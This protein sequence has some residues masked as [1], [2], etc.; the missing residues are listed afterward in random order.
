M[1]SGSSAPARSVVNFVED[2]PITTKRLNEVDYLRNLMVRHMEY[3]DEKLYYLCK[4]YQLQHRINM[5]HRKGTRRRQVAKQKGIIEEVVSI[6]D[7][8]ALLLG[9]N[10]PTVSSVRCYIDNERVELSIPPNKMNG[11]RS[12]I[13]VNVPDRSVLSLQSS[14]TSIKWV[15]VCKEDDVSIRD[16]II[17][18]FEFPF[19]SIPARIFF[20]I[21]ILLILLSIIALALETVPKYNPEIYVLPNQ[22]DD[23]DDLEMKWWIIELIVT[24]V[25]SIETVV[26]LVISR[27]RISLLKK[28]TTVTD[29][30]AVLPFYI[31]LFSSHDTALTNVLK[32]CRLFR[33]M[34]FFRNY[35]PIEN[36][37]RAIEKSTKALAAPMMFLVASL[38]VMSSA[39]YFVE[40]G[41]YDEI[42]QQFMVT[43]HSCTSRPSQIFGSGNETE[44]RHESKFISIPHTIWWSIVTMTTVGYG[45]IVPL[46][47]FG[48]MVGSLSMILGIMFMAMPIAIVGSYFTVVV[49]VSTES[50][51]LE[52]TGIADPGEDSPTNVS[53]CSPGRSL[54][55]NTRQRLGYSPSTGHLCSPT[56]P[57]RPLVSAL[58]QSPTSK[59]PKKAVK[60]QL[61]ES[62]RD[63]RVS[64]QFS[65]NRVNEMERQAANSNTTNLT[66]GEKL[67]VFL[68]QVLPE[69][70]TTFSS[71]GFVHHLDIWLDVN[72]CGAEEQEVK[73]RANSFADVESAASSTQRGGKRGRVRADTVVGVPTFGCL[74]LIEKKQPVFINDQN[75]TLPPPIVWLMRPMIFTVGSQCSALPDPDI[76]LCTESDLG[77]N[78]R[79]SQR[80]AEIL[81][82]KWWS[83]QPSCKLRPILPSRVTVNGC[84]IPAAGIALR[85]GDVVDFNADVDN[86]DQSDI[87]SPASIQP[88]SASGKRGVS[89]NRTHLTYRYRCDRYAAALR[90]PVLALSETRKC[91]LAT[92][93]FIPTRQ[94]TGIE[95]WVT[96]VSNPTVDLNDTSFGLTNP[97]APLALPGPSSVQS[98]DDVLG[99]WS[100]NF[101]ITS[102]TSTNIL[103]PNILSPALS[104]NTTERRPFDL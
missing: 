58:S 22:T 64:E 46:T 102:P 20:V 78:V 54:M 13:W 67:A 48:K 33:M 91:A 7:G 55:S 41:E 17:N 84:L 29:I 43:D 62:R 28:P 47:S 23:K 88:S 24:I 9:R 96:N 18:F 70:H 69:Y 42:A 104:I 1:N 39:V 87:N 103:K 11:E 40:K 38:L 31:E 74:E 8:R 51:M 4:N 37:I 3:L 100:Q 50:K 25:F 95:S 36:L 26:R 85:H 94:N 77:T 82:N 66:M 71:A 61:G 12:R 90:N 101:Q 83:D 32:L 56:A 52:K 73:S 89:T 34:K 93:D 14:W 45:E 63:S 49:D 80:H 16:E 76:V 10:L 6:G 75:L 27:N 86:T 44:C 5:K 65:K 2:L 30:L 79:V 59:D 97:V 81:V 72:N 53:P 98:E 92:Q 35:G 60:D 21:Q 99:D 68:Q 19:S 15:E 57:M